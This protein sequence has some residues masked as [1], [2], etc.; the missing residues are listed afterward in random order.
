MA[1]AVVI[2][3]CGPGR[4]AA[5]PSL[6][7]V[8]DR[9]SPTAADADGEYNRGVRAR[10]A[11]D[12]SAA[13]TAFR[14]ALALRAGFAEAWNELGYAL[15]HQGRYPESLD[16]YHEALRLR[17]DFPDALE[18]LGEVYVKLGRLDDPTAEAV[19]EVLREMFAL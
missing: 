9:P 14:R 6:P 4:I 7:S 3:A 1:A 16:A 2:L 11:R 12:W 13:V 10:V 19:L 17:P 5:D 8:S 18:Y 15:R